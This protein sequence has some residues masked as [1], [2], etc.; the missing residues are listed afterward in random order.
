MQWVTCYYDNSKL[1]REANVRPFSVSNARCWW[2][3]QKQAGEQEGTESTEE[4]QPVDEPIPMDQGLYFSSKPDSWVPKR[5]HILGVGNLGAFIAHSLAGIPN[6]PPITLL[7]R[8]N[9]FYRW[10]RDGS[11]INIITHGMTETR[12]GFEAEM[13]WRQEYGE[14]SLELSELQPDELLHNGIE[15]NETSLDEQQLSWSQHDA[16]SVQQLVENEVSLNESNPLTLNSA[17]HDTDDATELESENPSESKEL[18]E[19]EQHMDAWFA[20]ESHESESTA[21]PEVEGS[22]A[23]EHNDKIIYNLVVSV[24]APQTV[25][26]LRMLAH[27]LTKN[28]TI[29]FLQN[30]MGIIEEINKEVFPY[31][32]SRPTYIICVSTHGFNSDGLFEIVHAGQGTIALGVMPRMPMRKEDQ[33]SMS[34]MAASARYLIR[35]MTRAPVLVAVG[36]P[37][38]D[39]FQQQL[40]KLVANCVI[41]ALTAILECK[42][43]A[44]LFNYHFTRVMRLLLAEISLVVKNLPELQNVPNANTRFD[45]KRLEAMVVSIAKNTAQHDSSMLQDVRAG[46]QT[47]IDYLNGY[48]VR[49]GEEMGVHCVMNYMLLHM[50]KGRAKTVSLELQ[51]ALPLAGL[52]KNL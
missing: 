12:R 47:E 28:S 5:I 15:S 44:L 27:R 41:N 23:P 11:R 19:E 29:L 26:G 51:D 36:F 18:L 4:T 21:R 13:I 24:K 1:G 35:T 49:R 10:I 22:A 48:I 14:K 38:T 34:H 7:L 52:A 45:T 25:N 30:G 43:G 37:P 8:R 16:Q 50:L 2:P 33:K 31:E 17:T 42:N 32:E 20:Q 40:E 39:L 46:R 6:R 9:Q 3:V